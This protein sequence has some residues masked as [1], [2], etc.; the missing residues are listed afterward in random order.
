MT[1]KIRGLA[2]AGHGECKANGATFADFCSSI[3]PAGIALQ[4]DDEFKR[5]LYGTIDNG[6]FVGILLSARQNDYQTYVEANGGNIVIRAQNVNRDSGPYPVEANFICVRLDSLKGLYSYHAGSFPLTQFLLAIWSGY[7]AFVG[8]RRDEEEANF[9]AGSPRLADAYVLPRDNGCEQIVDR[10]D[11]KSLLRRLSTIN[12]IRFTS[13]SAD[14]SDDLPPGTVLKSSSTVLRLRETRL[15][16]ALLNAIDRLRRGKA[17]RPTRSGGTGNGY[18]KGTG[19]DG[20]EITVDFHRN[21]RD[22]L[23]LDERSVAAGEFAIA[24][25]PEHDLIKKMRSI[26]TTDV[27]LATNP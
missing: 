2:F 20:V 21:V 10:R 4:D 27:I 1:L 11:F 23:G 14:T 26:L 3:P 13:F 8:R 7:R 15:T 22:Y 16:E 5:I 19:Q 18:V 6:F 24:Q 9:L 25:L 17:W 12:E